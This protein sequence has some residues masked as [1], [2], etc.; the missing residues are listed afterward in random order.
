MSCL[1]CGPR[2][3]AAFAD[4]DL[5]DRI[6]WF[7]ARSCSA[8][9]GWRGRR[10]PT[11]LVEARRW[12]VAALAASGDDVRIDLERGDAAAAIASRRAAE[13]AGSPAAAEGA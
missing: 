7:T 10:G 9:S 5:V 6:V 2:L 12:Q 1:E 13:S 8:R 11:T 4:A 3:A